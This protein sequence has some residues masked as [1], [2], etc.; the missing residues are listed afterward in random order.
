MHYA[1]VFIVMCLSGDFLLALD[2]YPAAF[3]FQLHLDGFEHIVL[4]YSSRGFA[5]F[6]AAPLRLKSLGF[7]FFLFYRQ[8]SEISLVWRAPA[9]LDGARERVE[10]ILRVDDFGLHARRQAGLVQAQHVHS[11]FDA[12][13]VVLALAVGDNV[14][15]VFEDKAHAGQ[16]GFGVVLDA[17]II[18]IQEDFSENNRVVVEYAYVHI[19]VDI[20]A[21][22]YK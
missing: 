5:L 11:G 9:Q 21:R 6:L 1:A 18:L 14:G 8:Y 10:D 4:D 3:A 2:Q 13:E 16:A 12:G 15:A 22:A 19:D 7:L 17:V 20:V